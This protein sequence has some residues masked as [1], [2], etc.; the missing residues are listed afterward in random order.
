M[1]IPS[2]M[3]D[4]QKKKILKE[5]GMNPFFII[6][7]KVPSQGGLIINSEEEK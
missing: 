4:K 2:E 3:T 5:F 1:I 7:R 6:G